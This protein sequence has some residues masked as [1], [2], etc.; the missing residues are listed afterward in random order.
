MVQTRTCSWSGAVTAED[1]VLLQQQRV[2]DE[3]AAVTTS[4]RQKHAHVW[5]VTLAAPCT[6]Q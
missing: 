5:Q 6:L 2:R 1:L 3:L 4:A